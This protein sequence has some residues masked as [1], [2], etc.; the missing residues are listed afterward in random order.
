MSLDPELLKW[1][2]VSVV[3]SNASERPG[4]PD[5][6]WLEYTYRKLHQALQ[7]LP[8]KLAE[9]IGENMHDEAQSL[10]QAWKS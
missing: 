2:R 10:R 6:V 3:A 4:V 7:F 1:Y 9:W 8:N 5:R